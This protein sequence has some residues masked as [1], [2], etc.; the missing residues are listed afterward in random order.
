MLDYCSSD[1]ASADNILKSLLESSVDQR[2]AQKIRKVLLLLLHGQ[3]YGLDTLHQLLRSYGIYSN[4]YQKLWSSLSCD[5]LLNLVNQWLWCVFGKEFGKRLSQSKS[6]QSR[7]KLTLIIDGSIFKTW[8]KNEAFGQYFAKYFSGQYHCAINGF[9]VILCGMSIGEIFYPL[10]FQLRRKVEKDVDIAARIIQR[11]Y[12]KL[13]GLA[14]EIDT[15]LPTLYL[16]VDSG[17]R[18]KALINLCNGLSIIY[19][20]VPKSNH[21]VC[22]DLNQSNKLK[23]KDLKRDFLEKE[24]IFLDTLETRKTEIQDLF[25]WRIRVYYNCLKREVTLLLFRLKGSKKVSVIFTTDL[26][27]KGKTL[28]RHWFERTK[29]ELFFRCIKHS[30]SIQKSTVAYRLGFLK[31]LA[32]SFV[33]ALYAQ[34][35]T[36]KA[37]KKGHRLSRMGL[38]GMKDC[39]IF[40]QIHKTFMDDL[41]SKNTF[42]K[43]NSM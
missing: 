3:F 23:I 2:T 36:Q 41:V 43:T 26:N 8:L 39:I 12:V 32:F 9:N 19:I 38:E 35:F 34:L 16:S 18:S 40:H 25:T 27:V 7:Q 37:K 14:V 1:F 28:R 10:H 20:G 4:D 33:K 5:F 24:A 21:I 17:F 13:K 31:K 30:L 11:V 42:C 22:L 15:E 6:T 29:I